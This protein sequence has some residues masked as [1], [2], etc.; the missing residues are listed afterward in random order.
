MQADRGDE[1]AGEFAA[2]VLERQRGASSGGRL[3]LSSTTTASMSLFSNR[4]E[5]EEAA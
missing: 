5:E 2:V 4:G 3:S 1:A